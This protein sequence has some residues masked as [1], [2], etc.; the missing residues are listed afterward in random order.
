[1]AYAVITEN[2]ESQWSDETGVRYHFPSRYRNILLP[3]TQVIYYKGVL[4]NRLYR[5][6]RMHDSPHYFG[7]G[8]VGEVISDTK[9]KKKDLYAEILNYVEF[10]FP[11]V[12]K[13]DEKYVEEIPESRK[14]NYFRDGVRSITNNIYKKIL[15]SAGYKER[16]RVAVGDLESYAEGQKELIYTTRYERSPYLRKKV[17]EQKGSLCLCCGFD[18]F[19]VYGKIGKGYIQIHHTT[20]LHTLGEESP[21]SIDDLVPVCP[22]CHVMIHREKENTLSIDELKKMIQSGSL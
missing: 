4:K 20:P 9:S 6:K 1:M 2:D 13:I 5:E 21:V 15:S 11:V 16:D 7:C 17:I 22:N 8:I 10:D 19:K 12:F 14:V 3:G 18:F